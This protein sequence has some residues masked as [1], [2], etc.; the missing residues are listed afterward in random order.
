RDKLL[1]E[2]QIVGSEPAPK[3]AYK[4]FSNEFKKYYLK[5]RVL[6]FHFLPSYKDKL[7]HSFVDFKIVKTLGGEELNG[8]KKIAQLKPPWRECVPS[9]YAAYSLRVGV[10]EFAADFLDH[11]MEDVSTVRVS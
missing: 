2:D 10:K 7:P 9:R 5:N 8:K 11:V 3:K 1:P 4:A 6:E